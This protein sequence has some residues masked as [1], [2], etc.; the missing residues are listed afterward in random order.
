[1]DEQL[2]GSD[3]PMIGSFLAQFSH[4]VETVLDWRGTFVE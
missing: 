3:V 4:I 2:V 1:M